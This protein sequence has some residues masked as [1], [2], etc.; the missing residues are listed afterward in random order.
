MLDLVHVDQVAGAGDFAQAS[1][2]GVQFAGFIALNGHLTQFDA[3]VG[4]SGQGN[5]Q[6]REWEGIG[7]GG[8][9]RGQAPKFG[10]A[11]Q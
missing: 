2:C 8:T 7:Q 9:H 10:L 6:Q 1:T 11:G 3:F 5:A 4:V